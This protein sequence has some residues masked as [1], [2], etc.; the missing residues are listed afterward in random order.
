MAALLE[1]FIAGKWVAG[2][3]EGTL[4]SDPVTGEALVRVSSQGLDL[5]AAFGYARKQ[6]APRCAA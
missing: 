3:G 6:A 4:L 1:N 5:P 2:G